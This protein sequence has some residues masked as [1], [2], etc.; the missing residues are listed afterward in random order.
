MYPTK[1]EILKQ[2]VEFTPEEIEFMKKWKE[3]NFNGQ[4]SV[5]T[6]EEKIDDLAE[7]AKGLTSL[8]GK[9]IKVAKDGLDYY[10]NNFI[11]SINHKKPSIISTLHEVAHV[12][13]GNNE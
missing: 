11:I 5:K 4:W 8:R 6:K 1:E 3:E 7:L 13:F 10:A 12:L 2:K 9:N